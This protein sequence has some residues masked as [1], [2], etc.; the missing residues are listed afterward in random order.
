[1]GLG[2]GAGD[3]ENLVPKQQGSELFDE[4]FIYLGYG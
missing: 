3:D 4:G 1:M 2:D